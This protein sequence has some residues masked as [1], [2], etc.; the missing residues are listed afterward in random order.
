MIRGR[1]P[2]GKRSEE[3][4]GGVLRGPIASFARHDVPFE[5]DDDHDEAEVRVLRGECD[6]VAVATET[7]ADVGADFTRK[8]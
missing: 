2:Y 3:I 4:R 6:Y 8:L 5:Y 1:T 7:G